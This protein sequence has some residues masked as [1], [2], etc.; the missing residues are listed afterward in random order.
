MTLRFG[1]LDVGAVVQARLLALPEV[2][3]TFNTVRM[4]TVVPQ[5]RDYPAILHHI[6]SSNYGGTFSGPPSSETM[7]YAVR[8]L[9]E[10]ER[11]EPIQAAAEAAYDSF[12]NSYTED[13][14]DGLFATFDLTNEWP[15]PDVLDGS[16]LLSQLGFVLA[17]T[18]TQGG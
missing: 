11:V 18:V 9:I 15:Q 3:A 10:G 16:T 14:G 4:G 5:G 12:A 8:F 17:V 6:Q 7:N 2:A 13:L 1:S